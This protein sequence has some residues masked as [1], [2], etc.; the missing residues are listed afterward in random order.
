MKI[1]IK[2]FQGRAATHGF[3]PKDSVKIV[4]GEEYLCEDE[5]HFKACMKSGLVE[6]VMD[7]EE[8]EPEEEETT[9]PK[10][11]GRPPKV[12]SEETSELE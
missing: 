10:R 1:K 4:P 7:F 12:E 6:A 9:K 11:R 3:F 2:E 5:E 8:E